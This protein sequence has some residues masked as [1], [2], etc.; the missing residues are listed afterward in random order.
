[1]KVKIINIPKS[2]DG[3]PP[4]D[5]KNPES[6][7]LKRSRLKEKYEKLSKQFGYVDDSLDWNN[8]SQKEMD[9]F[10]GRMQSFLLKQSPAT[11][12]AYM[13]TVD[14]TNLGR[15]N[16]KSP[17]KGFNDN[18]WWF[19][20]PEYRTKEF[21]NQEDY[22]NYIKD[23]KSFKVGDK[24]YY[25]NPEG[26]NDEEFVH[27]L[28]KLNEGENKPINQGIVENISK[29]NPSLNIKAPGA[30]VPVDTKKNP[31]KKESLPFYQAAPELSG[32]ISALNPY[33][34]QTPDFTHWEINPPTLNIQSQL[35]SI[36][37]SLKGIN[38]STTG[39]PQ[40]DNIRKQSA[41]TQG[42]SAKQQAFSNKQNYDAEGRFKADSF[43][44]NARTQE[45]NLD[46]SAWN[47]IY[48]ELIPAAKDYA[49]GERLRAISSLTNKVAKHRAN[50]SMKKLYLDNFFPNYQLDGTDIKKVNDTEIRTYNPYKK[51]EKETLKVEDIFKKEEEPTPNMITPNDKIQKAEPKMYNNGEIDQYD[52]LNSFASNGA[53]VKKIRKY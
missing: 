13:N 41:F 45:Q 8:A 14:P 30:D 11:V 53:I 1:M 21:T 31:Y 22:N 38:D 16:S 24:D 39:N 19:R 26:N 40:I 9:S 5:D 33:T 28:L 32:F 44:I 27:P 50:E 47:N 42:L 15:R 34:Y 4:Y 43:N 36:D 35:Q 29:T 3:K 20:F 12:E 7:P 25:H 37:S 6:L 48:N 10:V 2:T 49:T 23:K 46:V 52:Y 51:E 17:A 18:L